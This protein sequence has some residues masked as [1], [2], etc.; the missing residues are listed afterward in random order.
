MKISVKTNLGLSVFW[1]LVACSQGSTTNGSNGTGGE[2]T[3]S[4]EPTATSPSMPGPS[5]SSSSTGTTTRPNPTTDPGG[6]ST[7]PGETSEGGG[8]TIDGEDSTTGGGRPRPPW[9][10]DSD[11]PNDTAGNQPEETTTSAEETSA[12]GAE[13]SEPA[14][15][16][17][18][19]VGEDPLGAAETCSSGTYWTRGENDRMRPGEACIA[20]HTAENE[21]PRY[22]IAGTLYPT[23]HEP[24]DCNGISGQASGA[25][26]V[27]TDANGEEHELTP[28]T[29]GN[30]FYNGN[31]AKPYTAKVVTDAGERLMV[32]PQ[33]DGDCNKCHTAE[34][35]GA[36]GRVVVPF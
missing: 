7:P 29:A 20:C 31:L 26:V 8:E 3:S 6:G 25:K 28:N 2:A 10:N 27:I 24:D 33:Q 34:G 12:A 23:G 9:A 11:E 5:P 19:P 32:T 14:V 35:S 22:A 21:G 15:T 17:E 16:T 18:A 4:E 13:T 1:L 36:P 30:F